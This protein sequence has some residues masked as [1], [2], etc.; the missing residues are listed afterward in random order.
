LYRNTI[1][2][3]KMKKYLFIILPVFLVFTACIKTEPVSV[4]PEVTFKSLEVGAGYDSLGNPVKRVIVEFNFIDGDANIGMYSTAADTIDTI[5]PERKN[6]VLLTLYYKENEDYIPVETT[7][8]YPEPYFR[9][10]YDEK[11]DRVGQNKTIKGTVKI[12]LDFYINPDYD[13]LKYDF[14]IKDRDNNASNV[15]ST[16]DFS[17]NGFD[18][19]PR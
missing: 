7:E 10:P 5:P 14:Y 8:D 3:E 15:A 4:I 1:N 11:L 19:P 18:F 16:D 12:D 17:L 6:N 2:S 13:T 9:I